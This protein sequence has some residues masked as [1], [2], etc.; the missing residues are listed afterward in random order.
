MFVAD[1]FSNLLFSAAYGLKYIHTGIQKKQPLSY[2]PFKTDT[3]T[4]IST[5]IVSSKNPV[6]RSLEQGFRRG[7]LK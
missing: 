5:C 7:T 1:F 2:E 4:I 3:S 6:Y